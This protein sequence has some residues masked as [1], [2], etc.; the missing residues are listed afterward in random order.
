VYVGVGAVVA[1][2]LSPNLRRTEAQKRKE[3]AASDGPDL[4]KP[5]PKKGAAAAT[6]EG[7]KVKTKTPADLEVEKLEKLLGLRC[8]EKEKGAPSA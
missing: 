3:A 4:K 8:A 6:D 1:L 5:P 2:K 7:D